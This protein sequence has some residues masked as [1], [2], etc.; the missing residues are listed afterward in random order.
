[1]AVEVL[2]ICQWFTGWLATAPTVGWADAN[3]PV[4]GG[5]TASCSSYLIA[6][7]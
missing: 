2:R 1:M 4:V 5:G 3:Y 6:P 7:G